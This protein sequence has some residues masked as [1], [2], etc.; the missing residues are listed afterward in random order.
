MQKQS[1]K[2]SCFY[3]RIARGLVIGL[4][5]RLINEV[6]DMIVRIKR[7]V[8]RCC[9]TQEQDTSVYSGQVNY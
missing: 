3:L 7:A 8:S 1:G 9:Y 6:I 5:S 2:C 4:G